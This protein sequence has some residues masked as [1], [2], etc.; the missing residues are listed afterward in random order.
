MFFKS[1]NLRN[2]RNF[3]EATISFGPNLNLFCG[4]NAQG[5]TNII[6]AINLFTQGR[7]FRT[8][9]YRDL[10][11]WNS[12]DAEIITGVEGVK[13]SDNLS[14]VLD[15]SKKNFFRNAKRT[16]PGGFDGVNSV[17]F[18]PEEILLLRDSP[19]ARRRYIDAFIAQVV[20]G[21]KGIMRNYEKVVSHKN[22]ILQDDQMRDSQK[23]E[24][25]SIWNE[26]L[27]ELGT[28]VVMGRNIWSDRINEIL[29][30]KYSA[31]AELDG[32]AE[33]CYRPN[34]NFPV[35]IMS[36]LEKRRRDEL[37]RRTSLV[38]PH[39][40][41]FEAM[42]NGTPIKN[43]GSQG[44]HRSFVLALKMT[45][46]A[47]LEKETGDLPVLLLDDVA[48]ELD[49]DRNQKFFEYL[50][51]TR[52]QVFITTTNEKDVRLGPQI[53]LSKYQVILGEVHR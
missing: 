4:N 25:I 31:F 49:S 34:C 5:K 51:T 19:S 28:K 20:S 41:D 27:A 10:I 14:V 18:A 33:F 47:I 2:F 40:D 6:E 36:Q 52:G 1:I 39:R 12:E 29:P 21:Y 8:S 44:Q 17:L 46:M 11:R 30:R 7:S 13:G 35:S 43:F 53:S 37:I 3:Q 42:I 48:S 23:N 50:T 26:Q 15:L 38:G 16:T 9:E 22:R 32:K 45:E 24:Q